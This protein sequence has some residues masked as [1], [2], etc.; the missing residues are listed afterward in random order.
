MPTVIELRDKL[1]GWLNGNDNRKRVDR[2]LLGKI[3][4]H[5]ESRKEQE[6]YCESPRWIWNMIYDLGRFAN[7][8]ENEDAAKTIREWTK[9]ATLEDFE[10]KQKKRAVPFLYL[11]Q[12]AARWVELE[13][14]TLSND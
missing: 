2:S 6:K 14:R 7:K 5:A 4:S 13:Q 10:F 11:L 9:R 12:T 3:D 1:R 8:I